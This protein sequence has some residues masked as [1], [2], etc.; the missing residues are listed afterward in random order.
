MEIE[1]VVKQIPRDPGRWS[2]NDVAQWLR[3]IDMNEYINTFKEGPVDGLN[4]F[5]LD[6]AIL[7]NELGVTKVLHRARILEGISRLKKITQFKNRHDDG[8]TGVSQSKEFPNQS[9]E[10]EIERPIISQSMEMRPNNQSMVTSDKFTIPPRI[11]LSHDPSAMLTKPGES[12]KTR[13]SPPQ[14]NNSP[15]LF[16][17]NGTHINGNRINLMDLLEATKENPTHNNMTTKANTSSKGR[18]GGEISAGDSNY[19]LILQ[20]LD[21]SQNNF[22]CV[23]TNGAKL[24][25]HSTNEIVVLEESVSRQH[26]MIFWDPSEKRYFLKDKGSTTGTFIKVLSKMELKEGLIVEMGSVQLLIVKLDPSNKM[27]SMK[28]VDGPANLLHKEYELATPIKVGRKPEN[29]LFYPDDL[30]LSN[31]HSEM[32]ISDQV[33]YL[34]D[35]AS[36]NGT[37]MRLSGEGQESDAYLLEEGIIFKVGTSSTFQVKKAA[38]SLQPVNKKIDEKNLCIICCEDERDTVLLPCRHQLTCLKCVKKCEIC[39]TCRVPITDSFRTYK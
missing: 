8:Y 14:Q 36:T 16:A 34:E 17:S 28:V 33:F 27:I 35:R 20:P 11:H 37:W 21:G 9:S 4:L 31:S 10:I 6:D 18:V 32:F 26:A 13:H 12:T 24:G 22:Y 3:L 38:G 5:K 1:E 23:T 29:H 15:S 30:H 7:A 19:E 39:P 2:T 25:R